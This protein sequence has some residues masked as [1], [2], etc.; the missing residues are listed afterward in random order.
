MTAVGE[1]IRPLAL[2]TEK[3]AHAVVGVSGRHGPHHGIHL[4][5][6]AYDANERKLGIRTELGSKCT[7]DTQ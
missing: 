5:V 3:H 2:L 1:V 6:M 4:V 7:A